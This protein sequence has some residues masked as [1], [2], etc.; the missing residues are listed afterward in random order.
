MS[1][2]EYGL[3][4]QIEYEER[5]E[6]ICFPRKRIFDKKKDMAG[7]VRPLM[8]VF[9]VMFMWDFLSKLKFRRGR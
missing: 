6:G 4:S 9:V 1:R 5:K 2:S 8:K 7:N 3:S